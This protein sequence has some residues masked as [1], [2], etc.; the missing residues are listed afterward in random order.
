MTRPAEGRTNSKR[1]VA[2]HDIPASIRESRD[3]FLATGGGESGQDI[4]KSHRR[5][6]LATGGT[7]KESSHLCLGASHRD[8]RRDV[9]HSGPGRATASRTGCPLRLEPRYNRRATA[10]STGAQKILG[11][12]E[13]QTPFAVCKSF[14]G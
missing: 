9:S 12:S 3:S 5:P 2:S 8:S 13:R 10:C 7:G 11:R 1:K 14:C 6:A 4:F